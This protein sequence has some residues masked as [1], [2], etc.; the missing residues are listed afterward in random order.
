MA[1]IKVFAISAAVSQSAEDPVVY[2]KLE[3]QLV[4][5]PKKPSQYALRGNLQ[6][7]GLNMGHYIRIAVQMPSDAYDNVVLKAIVWHAPVYQGAA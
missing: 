7:D 5:D 2:K 1:S 6:V 3:M 4:P